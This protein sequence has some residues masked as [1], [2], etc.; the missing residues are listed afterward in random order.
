MLYTGSK[1]RLSMPYLSVGIIPSK[2]T[3]GPRDFQGRVIIVLSKHTPTESEVAEA[4]CKVVRLKGE[5]TIV[6]RGGR[7][8]C[9]N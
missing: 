7:E 9:S 6:D 1:F 5:S 8:A 4:L 2:P 3:A